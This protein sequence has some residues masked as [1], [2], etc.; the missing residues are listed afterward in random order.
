MVGGMI[1]IQFIFIVCSVQISVLIHILLVFSKEL[2][3]VI[4]WLSL[5]FS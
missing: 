5:L 2:V 4:I 1:E 3:K